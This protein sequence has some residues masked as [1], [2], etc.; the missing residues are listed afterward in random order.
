MNLETRKKRRESGPKMNIRRVSVFE[1]PEE[2]E[3]D[4]A[5]ST[6]TGAKRKF[7]VQG[8]EEKDE[9]KGDAFRFSRRNNSNAQEVQE[10][11]QNPRP[12]S[13]A[14]PVLGAS[15]F[16]NR[17]LL[18]TT[19]LLEPVNT[20]PVVSPKKQR[21]LQENQDKKPLPMSKSRARPRINITR[22]VIEAQLPPLPM[23][24]PVQTAEII[25]ESLPPKT[26]AV[27][28]IFS[29][30]S[31]EPSTQRPESKDTPPPGDLT[32]SDQ[33]GQAGRPG[34][35]A[36]PQVSYKEPSLHTKMRR[37][38]A[39]L[40]DAVVDRRTS[41]EP[42]PAP[43]TT[44]KRDS[45][46]D[47]N[48]KPVSAATGGAGEEEGEVGSPLRQ[49]L[50][51]RDVS[52][53]SKT[54]Q[55]IQPEE[56]STASKAISALINETSAAKRKMAAASGP[57]VP[58]PTSSSNTQNKTNTS[59][60]PTAKPEGPDKDSLAVFDF[61]D[62][63]PAKPPR[64]GINDLAKAAR[65]AR[66]HSSIPASSSFPS[67]SL[68]D[69]KTAKAEGALPSLHKRTGSGTVK[70]S[71]SNI[72]SSKSNSGVPS[73]TKT[74]SA[75]RLSTTKD[76]KPPETLPLDDSCIDVRLPAASAVAE[77]ES[78]ARAMGATSK[79]RAERAASRRKSMML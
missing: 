24:E 28:E 48:W 62:S 76:K 47:L 59:R 31:T 52:H 42:Q 53:D 34:R 71:S 75:P 37:P 41:V 77:K 20:D 46:G 61:T 26:P 69:R 73:M 9:Q 66:R 45:T 8:D 16:P 33:T 4:A 27:E 13:P 51:R 72:H 1:S 7:S 14:R 78:A 18:S 50:D 43:S 70:S 64:A 3:E 23:P 56:R 60:E 68:E 17:I 36:R 19:D 22:N 79:L 30:P 74:T 54:T 49:K 21:S 10:H 65:S 5:K 11:G 25:L 40:V 2:L 44:I 67:S 63:S 57:V 38:D 55:P 39:K 12:A 29:P 32:S 58:E 35:R 15:E 6:R